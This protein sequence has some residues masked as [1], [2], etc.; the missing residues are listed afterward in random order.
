MDTRNIDMNRMHNCDS[1]KLIK[2]TLVW[3]LKILRKKDQARTVL[4]DVLTHG[5]IEEKNKRTYDRV[6]N[7]IKCKIP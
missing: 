3:K 6:F 2:K 5:L 1:L 4:Q 7:C